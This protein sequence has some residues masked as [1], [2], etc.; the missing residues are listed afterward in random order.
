MRI[1]LQARMVIRRRQVDLVIDAAHR[2]FDAATVAFGDFAAVD[3]VD[4]L[5]HYPLGHI[6]LLIT[7]SAQKTYQPRPY[8]SESDQMHCLADVLR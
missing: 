7:K 8:Q 3:I 1:W 2:K 6:Q 5:T 4:Q